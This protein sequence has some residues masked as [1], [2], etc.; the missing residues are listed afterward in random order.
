MHI[1]ELDFGQG[2]EALAFLQRDPVRNLRMVWALRRWGLFNLGLPEQCRYLAALGADGMQGLLLLNN[3]GMMRISARGDVARELAERALDS[4]GMPQVLAGPEEE[5]EE[6]L[7]AVTELALALEHREEETSLG[8]SAEGF[9][10]CRGGAE[11]ACEDDLDCLARLEGMLHEELLGGC[12]E[13]WII[14]SQISRYLEEGTAALVRLDGRAVAKAEI[15]A[16]TPW[17]DELGGVYTEP[18]HRSCGFAAAACSL[19]CESSLARGK[20]VRLETQRDN[21]AA[22]ALYRCLGFK[23]LFPHL[24]LRFSQE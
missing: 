1:A 17:V 21:A 19:V 9:I 12:P 10:P 2:R 3:Q 24:A 4:W 7:A 6:L 8:L 23:E 16:S 11:A 14:R 15:E 13:A 22:L 20:T 18:D 5:T